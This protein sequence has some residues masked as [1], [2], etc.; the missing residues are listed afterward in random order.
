MH[1]FSTTLQRVV[2]ARLRNRIYRERRFKILFVRLI[3]IACIYIVTKRVFCVLKRLNLSAHP[4]VLWPQQ[5]SSPW[6]N[7]M[8]PEEAELVSLSTDTVAPT[9]AAKDL[10]GAHQVREETSDVQE[11]TLRRS[12]TNNEYH[13]KMT[14]QDILQCKC[15]EIQWKRNGQRGGPEGGDKFIWPHDPCRSE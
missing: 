3:Q 15:K 14:K 6:L 9:D 5:M 10:L 4:L 13:D 2:A 11:E 7:P 1:G 8:C 12:S